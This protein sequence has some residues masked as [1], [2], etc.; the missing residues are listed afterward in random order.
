MANSKKYKIAIAAETELYL[1][2]YLARDQKWYKQLPDG[3]E[4]EL[5]KPS[6][7]NEDGDQWVFNTIHTSKVKGS[8]NEYIAGIGDPFKVQEYCENNH[9]TNVVVIGGLVM[10]MAFWGYDTNTECNDVLDIEKFQHIVCPS[11]GMT[12]YEVFRL[13][14]KLIKKGKDWSVT[15]NDKVIDELFKF[16]KENLESDNKKNTLLITPNI[17]EIEKSNETSEEP[18]KNVYSFATH[19]LWG[20]MIITGI[21]TQKDNINTDNEKSV[22]LQ[23]IMNAIQFA[24][25]DIHSES[26]KAVESLLRIH[27]HHKDAIEGK[28]EE[29]HISSYRKAAKECLDKMIESNIFPLDMRITTAAWG[30]RMLLH[31]YVNSKID[32]VEFP[33]QKEVDEKFIKHVESSVAK[34]A[35]KTV[36]IDKVLANN[37]ASQEVNSSLQEDLN[38]IKVWDFVVS[39]LDI[40]GKNMLSNIINTIF[41]DKIGTVID[42]KNISEFKDHYKGS[43]ERKYPKATDEKKQKESLFKDIEVKILLA[44]IVGNKALLISSLFVLSASIFILMHYDWSTMFEPVVVLYLGLIFSIGS[45]LID[46]LNKHI[47]FSLLSVATLIPGTFFIFYRIRNNADIFSSIKNHIK[48]SITTIND[49]EL[50]SVAKIFIEKLNEINSI[51]FY[52]IIIQVIGFLLLVKLVVY[53]LPKRINTK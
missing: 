39:E 36:V 27:K 30:T 10:K 48:L 25:I 40:H 45:L 53:M 35:F 29:K 32:E 26:D 23:G 52:T 21:I 41:K 28:E 43:V 18:Y 6:Q 4:I 24:L 14:E 49:S 34:N 5:D 1:P 15:C 2:L 47:S 31:K 50:T 8:Y 9:V 37:N 44:D 33:S 22:I 16:F 3:I 46:N 38:Y 13:T 19:P 51:V 12:G 17:Y 7:Q 20:D 11:N 42:N